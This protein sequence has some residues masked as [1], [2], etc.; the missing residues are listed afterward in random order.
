[1]DGTDSDGYGI[2]HGALREN[3]L[4]LFKIANRRP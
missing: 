3:R 1:M 2:E 4:S